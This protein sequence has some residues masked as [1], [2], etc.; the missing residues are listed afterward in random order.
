MSDKHW[1]TFPPASTRAIRDRLIAAGDDA[2]LLIRKHGDHL[3]AEAS[4]GIHTLDDEPPPPINDSHIH[5]P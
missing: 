4:G 3:T 5:P 2:E 1:W